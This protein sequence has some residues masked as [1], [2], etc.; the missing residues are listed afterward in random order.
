MLN[1]NFMPLNVI[2]NTKILDVDVLTS[3]FTFVILRK[4]TAAELSQKILM[5]LA[6]ESTIFSLPMKFLNHNAYVVAS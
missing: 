2:S 6:I 5:G 4:E 1:E 3:T